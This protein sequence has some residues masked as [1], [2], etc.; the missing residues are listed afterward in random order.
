MACSRPIVATTAG[1]IPEVVADGE[2]GLLVPPRDHRAMAD[3]IQLL[4][5]DPARRRAMGAAGLARVRARF[6]VERMVA[7]TA[8]VY[9]AV[10][11]RRRA[12]GTARPSVAD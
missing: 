3:A 11:G 7:G 1:G 4:L 10:A 8:D 9:A 6:T 5:G 2:T 12:A